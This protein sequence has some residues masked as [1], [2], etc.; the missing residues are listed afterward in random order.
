MNF[1]DEVTVL[2][3]YGEDEYGNPG[4]SW[5]DPT[6]IEAKGFLVGSSL[7]MPAD[8]DVQTGDRVTVG[9]KTYLADVS[10]ARS[11]QRTVMLIV[12]L[13]EVGSEAT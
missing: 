12:S 7:L 3:P 2:R 9:G 6:V 13:G 5:A 1:S 11:P 10:P 4:N 8:S